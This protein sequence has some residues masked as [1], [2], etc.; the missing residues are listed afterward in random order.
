MK[1]P[2]MKGLNYVKVFVNATIHSMRLQKKVVKGD[3]I[4]AS[5]QQ[6]DGNGLHIPNAFQFG[7]FDHHQMESFIEI[8]YVLRS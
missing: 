2:W 4:V 5:R 1:F 8:F 3:V 6:Y 7:L